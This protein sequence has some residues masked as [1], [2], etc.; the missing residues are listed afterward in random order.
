MVWVQSQLL[1]CSI[2][3]SENLY[4]VKSC[5]QN[6][7]LRVRDTTLS[8]FADDICQ[9]KKREIRTYTNANAVMHMLM[10]K[11]ICSTKQGTLKSL[12][13]EA[14]AGRVAA[15]EWMER[16]LSDIKWKVQAQ[17]MDVCD[18][19]HAV[20]GD[21]WQICGVQSVCALGVSQ[22]GSVWLDAL[23]SFP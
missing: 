18:S 7:R 13:E 11:Q 12:L 16:G 4:R 15:C 23:F 14:G 2:L 1:P 9:K 6:H 3:P 17:D 5:D 22:C 21:S 8:S 20:N 19:L 10:A